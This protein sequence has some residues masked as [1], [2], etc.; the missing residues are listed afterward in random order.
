MHVDFTI[1]FWTLLSE[2]IALSAMGRFLLFL[3]R[4]IR[5][6]VNAAELILAQHHEVYGW[7]RDVKDKPWRIA[8]D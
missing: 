4:S 2:L 3:V 6:V 8:G 1:H 5:S 7:Y